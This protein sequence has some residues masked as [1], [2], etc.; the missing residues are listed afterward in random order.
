MM[1]QAQPPTALIAANNTLALGALSYLRNSNIR[2]PEDI[3]FMCYGELQ[4]SALLYIDPSYST[5]SPNTMGERA[6]RFLLDRMG[7]ANVFNRQ[8][9]FESQIVI[10]KSVQNA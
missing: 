3:S 5:L 4:N 8:A 6:A 1:A 9:I 2:V 7:N 10:G